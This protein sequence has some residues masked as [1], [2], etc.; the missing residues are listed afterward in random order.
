MN[1]D[2]KKIRPGAYILHKGE[3]CLVKLNQIV[4][5]GTHSHAKNKLELEGLFSGKGERLVLPPHEK[6]E[7]LE[8]IKKLGQLISKTND[9]VQIMD[10]NTYETLD[11]EIDE[12]I[13]ELNEGDQVT[14]VD[15]NGRIRILEK[16]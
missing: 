11:A 16:R 3:P 14:F 12:K 10:M 15:F 2:I 5:T 1:E 4:V 7:T 8:I 9:K 13:E 6:L